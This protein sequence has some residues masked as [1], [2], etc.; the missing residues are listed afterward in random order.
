MIALAF[1]PMAT[2]TKWLMGTDL[3]DFS[4]A[5]S[6]L[7]EVCIKDSMMVLRLLELGMKNIHEFV[8]VAVEKKDAAP[9]VGRGLTVHLCKSDPCKAKIPREGTVCVPPRRRS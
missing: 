9:L 3:I 4:F 1:T 8:V 6:E 5:K 2:K 7:V